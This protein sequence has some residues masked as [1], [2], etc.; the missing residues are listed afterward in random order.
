MFV[1]TVCMCLIDMHT[2]ASLNE[3]RV[4]NIN[5]FVC[6]KIPSVFSKARQVNVGP[7]LASD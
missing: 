2:I 3:C 4:N 1:Y 7:Y 6:L 5:V